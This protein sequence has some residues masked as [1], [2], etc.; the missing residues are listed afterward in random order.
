M[1]TDRVSTTHDG[2]ET[3][4]TMLVECMVGAATQ[5]IPVGSFN[6]HLKPYWKQDG[7]NDDHY[8]MRAARRSWKSQDKPRGQNSDFYKQYK[9]AKREFRRRHR[10]SK[11]TFCEKS[12]SELEKTCEAD[13]N[14]FY[15]SVR[16]LRKQK[17]ELDKLDYN[18]CSAS[19]PSDICKLWGTYYADLALPYECE[20][21]DEHFKLATESKIVDIKS[22][23]N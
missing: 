11:R 2:I 10:Y 12:R 18:N 1:D 9:E 22:S 7:L 16:K 3:L 6:A 19:D 8:N 23:N 5:C 21:F 20:H 17:T 13:V 15:K 14:T 4:N